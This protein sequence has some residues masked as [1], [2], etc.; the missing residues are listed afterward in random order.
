V[1]L[2]PLELQA[3]LELRAQPGLLE[4]RAQLARP[5]RKALQ[6]LPA[7]REGLLADTSFRAAALL[8]CQ[9]ELPA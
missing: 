9:L 7:R 3:P 8:W 5:D 4:L 6:D 1:P 2:V